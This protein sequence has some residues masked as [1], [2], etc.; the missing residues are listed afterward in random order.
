MI[1][2]EQNRLIFQSWYFLSLIDVQHQLSSSVEVNPFS[3]LE[4]LKLNV[5][6]ASPSP[7]CYVC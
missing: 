7:S 2:Q 3:L 1:G 6:D 5:I 4:L